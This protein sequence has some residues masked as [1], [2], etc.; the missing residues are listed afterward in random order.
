MGE[1]DCKKAPDTKR[2]RRSLK[3]KICISYIS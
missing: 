1:R 3:A 2:E